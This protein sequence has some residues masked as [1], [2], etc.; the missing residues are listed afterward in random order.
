MSKQD[1][2]FTWNDSVSLKEFFL[3]KL[4]AQEKALTLAREIMNTR[5]ETMNEFREQLKSQAGTFITRSEHD[6]LANE[7]QELREYRARIEG[8]ASLSS[9][10]IA[11]ALSVIG[12]FIAIIHLFR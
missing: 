1:N 8:K 7:I 11:Y 2:G 6:L 9:V 10:Y 3:A 12:I 4:E 5:L